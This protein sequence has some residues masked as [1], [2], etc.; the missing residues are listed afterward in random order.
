MPQVW[1]ASAGQWLDTEVREVHEVPEGQAEATVVPL[2]PVVKTWTSDDSYGRPRSGGPGNRRVNLRDPSQCKISPEV[3]YVGFTGGVKCWYGANSHDCSLKVGSM[4]TPL[5]LKNL[6]WHVVDGPMRGGLQRGMPELTGMIAEPELE[7]KPKPEPKPMKK[8]ESMRDFTNVSDLGVGAYAKVVQA[9]RVSDGE[10]VAI[11]IVN[12]DLVTKHEREKYVKT[13]RDILVRLKPSP[14]VTNLHSTFQSDS[15]VHY[16]M[17]I[18]PHGDL[19]TQIELHK[20]W[21]AA[22][23]G[24]P[25]AT[26]QWWA[27]ELVLALGEIFSHGVIHRDIKPDNILLSKEGHIKLCDFGTAKYLYAPAGGG[28]SQADT[29]RACSFVGSADYI[30]PELLADMP[31]AA[32]ASSDLWALGCVVYHLLAGRPPFLVVSESSSARKY[33]TMNRIKALQYSFPGEP[34]GGELVAGLKFSAA[35]KAL[36]QAL[37]VQDPARRLGA[38]AVGAAATG[39]LRGKA[40]LRALPGEDIDATIAAGAALLGPL[41]A[42]TFW[43][44]LPHWDSLRELDAPQLLGTRA[45]GSDTLAAA[46]QIES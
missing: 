26:V 44:G 36:V 16:V 6:V 32:S 1:S 34:T 22:D 33:E 3:E 8:K 10:I 37:L 5:V 24:V 18:C 15:E 43:D 31:T 29:R 7:P 28:D 42:H 9:E 41:K 19:S 45:V 39:N 30:S 14:S 25:V 11:K 40:L 12:K 4:V 13:E 23:S 21:H 46:T 35:A 2:V 20:K 17:E 27:A 38:D